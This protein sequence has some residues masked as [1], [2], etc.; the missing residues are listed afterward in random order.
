MNKARLAAGLGVVVFALGSSSAHAALL[1]DNGIPSLSNPVGSNL[2]D[3]QQG[4]DFYLAST[5][6]LTSVRF[7]TLEMSSLDYLNSIFWE[8]RTNASGTPGNTVIASGTANPTRT[9]TTAISVGGTNFNQNQNDFNVNVNNLAS[10]FYWLTLHNGALSSN[11]FTDFYW[12]A[13]DANAT[14]H[15]GQEMGLNPATSWYTNDQELAFQLYGTS[16]ATPE[17]GTLGLVGLS[18]VAAGLI[19]R[20]NRQD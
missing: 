19:R 12:S 1:V 10:G 5:T 6:S 3:T 4:Q 9:A 13:A 15:A 16:T 18:L 11:T 7:W 17:P 8:I 2:S 20:T 14:A